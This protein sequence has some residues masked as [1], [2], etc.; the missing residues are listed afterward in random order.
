MGRCNVVAI[1]SIAA[2]VCLDCMQKLYSACAILGLY[3]M[4]LSVVH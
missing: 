2:M 1:L 4:Y 3:G